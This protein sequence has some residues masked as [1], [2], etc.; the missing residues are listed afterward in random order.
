MN[1]REVVG[2]DERE[3]RPEVQAG[4]K[5]RRARLGHHAGDSEFYS[6]ATV[7]ETD[8]GR[9]RLE[10]WTHAAASQGTTRIQGRGLAQ[11]LC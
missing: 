6:T 9:L 8:C 10:D 3:M 11:L 5:S 1:Q 4:A 7:S 2:I